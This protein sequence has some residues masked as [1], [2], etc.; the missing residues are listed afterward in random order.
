[1][2]LLIIRLRC[3]FKFENY[4][5]MG[6]FRKLCCFRNPCYDSFTHLS[7]EVTSKR[8]KLLLT[9]R[10]QDLYEKLP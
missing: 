9:M 5:Y 4:L 6:C 2:H 7:S 1:M 10:M 3:L 8:A